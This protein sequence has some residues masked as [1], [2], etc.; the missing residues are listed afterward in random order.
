MVSALHFGPVM[1]EAAAPETMNTLF[2]LAA[3]WLTASATPEF[4]TS[5]IMSTLSTSYHWLARL[6]PTSG[7]F[8]W[9][10]E[11]RSTFTLG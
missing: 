4:G 11:I 1:S 10:P 3:T 9:S 8:W 2:L 5:M 6:V 7:L